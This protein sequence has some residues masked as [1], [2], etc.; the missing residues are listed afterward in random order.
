MQSIF[1][2]RYL[3]V[4]VLA[5]P[6]RAKT[7]RWRWLS[8]LYSELMRSRYRLIPLGEGKVIQHFT[9]ALAASKEGR[10]LPERR[11]FLGHF[12]NQDLLARRLV[13]CRPS[14]PLRKR[15][16][17]R[18]MFTEAATTKS[19]MRLTLISR[20]FRDTK[21]PCPRAM[22]GESGSVDWHS[23]KNEPFFGRQHFKAS[24]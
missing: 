23:L 21:L 9:P 3:R 19:L 11:E 2:F 13:P 6:D 14:T 24:T 10:S 5:A 18:R 22:R 16:P 8:R 17:A 7:G 1:M 15:A 20:K 4:S 12:L